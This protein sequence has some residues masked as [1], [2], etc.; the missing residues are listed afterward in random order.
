MVQVLLL[1]IAVAVL[2]IAGRVIAIDNRMRKAA[3]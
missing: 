1:V 2:V 3:K